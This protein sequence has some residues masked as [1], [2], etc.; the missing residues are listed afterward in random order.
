MNKTYSDTY[1]E[2]SIAPKYSPGGSMGGGSLR[3]GGFGDIV[4]SPRDM[5]HYILNMTPHNFEMMREVASQLTGGL[6]SPMWG[7]LVGNEPLEASPEDYED[8]IRMP[9]IPATARMLDVSHH[10]LRGGGFYSALKHTLHH[11]HKAYKASHGTISFI[12]KYR[13][14]I[15]S[16]L[17]LPGLNEYRAAIDPIL[18]TAVAYDNAINPIYEA[19]KNEYEQSQN[20][21]TST[22]STMNRPAS[23]STS[24]RGRG[25]GR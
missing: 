1:A 7:K 12:N 6:P 25:R 19:A 23:G 17:A 15:S 13:P 22:S 5:Y 11:A 20:P 18:D 24:T 2:H 21:N 16:A 8:I 14:L 4:K 3:G 9:S 10:N